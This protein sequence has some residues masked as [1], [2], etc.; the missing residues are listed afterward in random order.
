MG[1]RVV[2]V[3][4]SEEAIARLVALGWLGAAEAG[5]RR[6]VTA[7]LENLVDCYSRATLDPEP[8]AVST[9]TGA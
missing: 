6:C 7:A 1:L 3:E 8:V 5:D 4:V 2:Q 9:S